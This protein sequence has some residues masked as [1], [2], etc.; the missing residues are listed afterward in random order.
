MDQL[1]IAI[2]GATAV[3]LTQQHRVRWRRYAC[4]VG[5]CSQPFWFYAA[6]RAG[7][8]GVFVSSFAFTYGWLVGLRNNWLQEPKVISRE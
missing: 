2:L 5:L 3:W 7:Q 1:A 6:W 8:W 4:L